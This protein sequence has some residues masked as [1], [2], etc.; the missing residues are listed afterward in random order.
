VPGALAHLHGTFDLIT[1]KI[2]LHGM[3]IMEATLPRATSGVKS[4]LLRAVDPF[5]KKNRHGRAKF[6]VS[7]TGTYQ[8]PEY[9]A[10]P[11]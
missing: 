2:D 1:E 3:L 4:F 11:I 5:L 10:D 7:I 9:R 8:K 6:P